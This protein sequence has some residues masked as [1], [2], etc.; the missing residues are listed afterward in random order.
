LSHNV[1]SDKHKQDKK[2]QKLSQKGFSAVEGL[3]VLIVVLAIAGVGYFV[4]HAQ[5]KSSDTLNAATTTA[6]QT[7]SGHS[8]AKMTGSQAVVFVQ[9]AYNKYLSA[10]TNAAAK[11]A[12][13]TGSAASNAQPIQANGLAVIKPDLSTD[14]YKQVSPAKAGSDPIGCSPQAAAD[15]Y[16]A[17]LG[18]TSGDTATVNVTMT[19]S[20]STSTINV[21]VDLTA[22]KITGVTCPS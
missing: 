11:N 7:V 8:L 20:G 3:L 21:M 10:E 6:N 1:S 15:S 16:Q 12:K 18:S 17:K 9:N 13:L 5:Q 22:R 14:F 19:H 4:F 2:M